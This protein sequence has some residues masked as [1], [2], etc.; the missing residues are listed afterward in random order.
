MTRPCVNDGCE[1]PAD[2]RHLECPNCLNKTE[3]VGCE[4]IT[5]TP[6]SCP[7]CGNPSCGDCIHLEPEEM[8]V[9][10]FAAGTLED[11]V[12]YALDMDLPPFAFMHH[13]EWLFLDPTKPGVLKLDPCEGLQP[14]KLS[15]KTRLSPE[16][17]YY[18]TV[19]A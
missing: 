11:H 12:G 7:L 19:G 1:S 16:G 9:F 18:T 17:P 4:T 8:C 5:V 6:I 2:T 3:C 14:F 13:G 15:L 10:C